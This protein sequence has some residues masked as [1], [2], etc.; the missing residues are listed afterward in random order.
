MRR[1]LADSMEVTAEGDTVVVH[2]RRSDRYFLTERER[3]PAEVQAGLTDATSHVSDS[4]SGVLLG[5]TV[6]LILATV[7]VLAFGE[8]GPTSFGGLMPALACYG[9]VSVAVHEGAHLWALH[10]CGRRADRVGFKMHYLVLPAFYVRMNQSVLLARAERIFVHVAGVFANLT[11][12]LLL[13][14]ANL[15]WWR[16]AAAQEAFGIVAVSILLNCAPFLNSDG[17]R[18]ILALSNTHEL[19]DRRRN[20]RW[21]V[22]LK[23]VSVVFVIWY[24]WTWLGP[25]L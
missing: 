7:F 18:V 25:L 19:K 11:L 4:Q 6:L 23:A 21:I 5:S 22:A 3:L 14:L 10:H 15:L 17:Y 16:A 2:D 12:G 9:V 8:V 13:M 24:T 1:Y 20:P